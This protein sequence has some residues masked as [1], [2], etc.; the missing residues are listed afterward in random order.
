MGDSGREEVSRRTGKDD[1]MEGEGVG[2]QGRKMR[3]EEG[4]RRTGKYDESR[5]GRGS[6][7][8]GKDDES[9]E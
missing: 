5:G 8:T 4:S 9:G 6:R 7:R 1:E 2:E 3:V